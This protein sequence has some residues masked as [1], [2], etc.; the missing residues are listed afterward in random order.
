MPDWKKIL[1]D[2]FKRKHSKD[3]NRQWATYSKQGWERAEQIA[4]EL[5]C[6]VNQVGSLLRDSIADSRIERSE[7]LIWNK[8]TEQLDKV[9][10][11]RKVRAGQK[12]VEKQ[13]PKKIKPAVGMKVRSR[14]GTNGKI[15][16]A[17]RT[18]LRVEWENGSQTTPLLTGL[19]KGDIYIVGG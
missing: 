11:Y 16:E 7:F 17:G 9:V 4:E 6:S 1:A 2:Q 3:P 10:A 14:R 5:D 19:V 15:L 18:R 13:K 8:G 12:A